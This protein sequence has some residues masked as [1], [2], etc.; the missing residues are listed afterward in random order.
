MALVKTVIIE[1]YSKVNENDIGIKRLGVMAAHHQWRRRNEKPMAEAAING[2][3]M[4][5]NENTMAAMAWRGVARRR[6]LSM[7]DIISNLSV[8]AG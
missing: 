2:G 4:W 7:Y 5:R 3:V 6:D 8:V 1:A